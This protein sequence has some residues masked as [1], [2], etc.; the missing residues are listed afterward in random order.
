MQI[1]SSTTSEIEYRVVLV[2]DEGSNALCFVRGDVRRLPRISMPRDV[3]YVGYIQQHFHDVY[4]LE[5][6][7][8]E[9]FPELGL[10][11]GYVVAEILN[12]VC[13]CVLESISLTEFSD[14]ELNLN[15]RSTL[16]SIVNGRTQGWDYS[17]GSNGVSRCRIGW[18]DP[19][20]AR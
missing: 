9:I 10:R 1:A 5:V 6:F 19:R 14:D 17:R 16:E 13:D 3:R 20:G 15:E 8:V 12:P 11:R 18:Q 4:G 7:V 2:L